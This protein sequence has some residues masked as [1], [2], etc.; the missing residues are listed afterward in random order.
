MYTVQFI[1]FVYVLGAVTSN[2]NLLSEYYLLV[3]LPRA[4]KEWC[5][6]QKG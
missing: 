3:C 1:Y 2:N 5:V 4:K 6:A